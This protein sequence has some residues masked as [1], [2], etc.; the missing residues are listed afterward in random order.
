MAKLWAML[1]VHRTATL[2]GAELASY[3]GPLWVR[4]LDFPRVPHLTPLTEHLSARLTD[5]QNAPWVLTLVVQ[6]TNHSDGLTERG[7]QTVRQE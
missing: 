5:P 3:L 1:T 7:L 4:R 2:M 6:R